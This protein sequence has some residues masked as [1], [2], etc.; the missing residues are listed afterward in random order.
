MTG[1]P[2]FE[3]WLEF[4]HTQPREGDDP[5]DDFCNVEVRLPDGRRYAL[6]VWTFA[7]LHRAMSAQ[8]R[9]AD[10]TASADYLLP[11][12]LL[13]ARLDRP[14]LAR[15]IGRML[16]AGEMRPEWLSPTEVTDP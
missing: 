13:V 5:A 7:H 10:A 14:T 3:L 12:D 9:E 15:V 16:A 11:P 6:N 2:S 4:E 8:P 1:A